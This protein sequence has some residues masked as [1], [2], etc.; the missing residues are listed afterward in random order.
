LTTQ[1]YILKPHRRQKKDRN[2]ESE[3]WNDGKRDRNDHCKS[4]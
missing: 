3:A 4:I 2:E 1:N